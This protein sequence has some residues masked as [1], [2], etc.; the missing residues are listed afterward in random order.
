MTEVKVEFEA[1]RYDPDD[2]ID[3]A[4]VAVAAQPL[5][6]RPSLDGKPAYRRPT[7]ILSPEEKALREAEKSRIGEQV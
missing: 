1:F 7:F 5:A 3:I 4:S 2:K 6:P